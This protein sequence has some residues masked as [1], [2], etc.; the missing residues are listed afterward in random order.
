VSD[1]FP[2]DSVSPTVPAHAQSRE[3]REEIFYPDHVKRGAESHEFQETKKAEEAAGQGCFICEITQ[4]ELPKGQFLEGHHLNSEWALVNSLDLAKVQ[5]YFPGATDLATFLDSPNN[6]I[7]LCLTP[8]SPVLMADGSTKSICD[9][10]VGDIILGGD[11]S[12]DRVTAVVS[13]PYSGNTFHIGKSSL[14]PSHSVG[15]SVGWKPISEVVDN[16]GMGTDDMISLI[17]IENQIFGSVIGPVSV[18]VVNSLLFE[19]RTTEDLL[20]DH[21]MLHDDA[22][23]L[24]IENSDV[25]LC[26]HSRRSITKIRSRNFIEANH[27]TRVG[28][29]FSN[30]RLQNLDQRSAGF[31]LNGPEGYTTPLPSDRTALPG[32]SGNS[33]FKIGMDKV[34][35]AAYNALSLNSIFPTGIR[36]SVDDGICAHDISIPHYPTKSQVFVSIKIPKIEEKWYEGTVHDIS[37]ERSGSFISSGLVVHNCPKHHRAPLRGVHMV[38]HPAWVVQRLQKDGWDLVTGT[39][40]AAEIEDLS[41]YYPEH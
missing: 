31:T 41:T 10:L 5:K 7:L 39:N 20:R 37:V 27:S 34:R 28:T 8:E 12:P 32:T 6:L 23:S 38:T 22:S 15:T 29:V 40:P 13:K 26:A 2:L 17:G 33:L 11:G 30:R 3:L 14:T 36:S 4:A 19:E 24:G 35:G 21:T 1:F 25:T 18:D 9:I 16:V